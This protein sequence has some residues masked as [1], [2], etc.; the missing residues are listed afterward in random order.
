MLSSRPFQHG[1]LC[2]KGLDHMVL[3]S[4]VWC[5]GGLCAT[6]GICISQHRG[7]TQ[8]V[9]S[10]PCQNYSVMLL[11]LVCNSKYQPF[12]FASLYLI[13]FFLAFNPLTATIWGSCYNFFGKMA[14]ESGARLVYNELLDT[15]SRGGGA[16]RF[17]ALCIRPLF[18]V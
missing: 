5:H 6:S 1:D 17:P 14:P 2:W 18:S 4:L 10:D 13:F 3:V 7:S 16:V 8:S 9:D 11:R 12:C 15:T